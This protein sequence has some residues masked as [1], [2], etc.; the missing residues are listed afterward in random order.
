MDLHDICTFV[1]PFR[2][3]SDERLRNLKAV[4]KWNEPLNA[5][6]I[7]LEA[8]KLPKA[9]GVSTNPNITYIFI[10][11]VNPIFYR[12]RYINK[13]M[14]K[15]KTEIVAV[16]DADV[17]VNH[18]KIDEAIHSIIDDGQTIVYP[19][20]SR[21]VYLSEEETEMFV[22]DM[23]LECLEQRDLSLL[24]NRPSCGG[25]YLAHK[26]RYL[27]LGGENEKFIG[28]GP[29]DAERMRRVMIMNGGVSWINSGRAYHLNHPRLE[30]SRYFNE[31]VAT[32]LRLEFVKV[33]SMD[34]DELSA[35]I[36]QMNVIK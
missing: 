8:D 10:E 11:D 12:T 27:A 21:L 6:I 9:D 17:I 5:K 20:D 7:L 1:I 2:I 18:S 35:Y 3:D 13:M 34:K 25:V 22:K 29:E 19:Y 14:E 36:K 31:D 32:E 33:C 15:V 30:N 28:W 4:L 26:K 23:D 24:I 16:L